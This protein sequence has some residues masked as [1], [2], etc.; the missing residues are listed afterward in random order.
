MQLFQQF[1]HRKEFSD[2][3]HSPIDLQKRVISI[4]GLS[5]IS[6]L[7]LPMIMLSKKIT[8]FRPDTG[9]DRGKGHYFRS[10]VSVSG[11]DA[12]LLQ[13]FL[14]KTKIESKYDFKFKK[15]YIAWKNNSK[16]FNTKRHSLELRLSMR[17]MVPNGK[18]M[19][20]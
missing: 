19:I 11:D 4:P 16:R 10:P 6:F 13:T 5:R 14:G 18:K 7:K 17:I 9:W 3:G 8:W 15:L 1:F 2:F 20:I 12:Q